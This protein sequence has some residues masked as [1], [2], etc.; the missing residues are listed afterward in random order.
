MVLLGIPQ[1]FNHL[2]LIGMGKCS[3]TTNNESTV[4]IQ[5][6]ND[7]GSNYHFQFINAQATTPAANDGILTY[8]YVFEFANSTSGNLANAAGSGT[9]FIPFYTNTT[10]NKTMHAITGATNTNAGY[11]GLLT[12]YWANSANITSLTVIDIAGGN[13]LAGTKFCLYGMY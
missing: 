3:D 7:T 13:F 2:Q 4:G 1:T 5:F 11:C 10:Y 12:G 8:I 9:C 6:N